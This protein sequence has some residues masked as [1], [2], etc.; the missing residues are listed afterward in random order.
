MTL[1][2]SMRS[3]TGLALMLTVATVAL[4]QPAFEVASIRVRQGAPQWKFAISGTRLTIESYTLF[5]LIREAYDLQIY[6]FQSTGAPALLQSSDIL[7]D[8][9]AKAQG[10][11]TPTRNQFRQM[12]QALLAD[13]FKLKVHR[14]PV[15]M[16]VYALIVGRGGPKF[17]PS[18]PDADPT[19]R[20]S[21]TPNCSS[22]YVLTMPKGTMEDLSHNL[23]G[24]GD[25]PVVD[26]TGLTGTFDIKLTYKPAYIK[27]SSPEPDLN[28]IS[29]FTAVQDQLG[30][31]L[32]P[33]KAMIDTLVVD[34][35]EKPS[36][37]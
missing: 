20:I 17:K 37:N 11:G 25:R 1:E 35:V 2:E 5:G 14:E 27:S 21:C 36:E 24:A 10:D 32:E 23:A 7:Y 22:N 9:T 13:R 15:E 34:H 33:R 29:I 19:V 31:K 18:S 4:G 12:L 28:D 30:L 6:Q 16:P 26:Q 3:A 8:I